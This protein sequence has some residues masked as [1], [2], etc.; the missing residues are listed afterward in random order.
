[1]SRRNR[2]DPGPTVRGREL[3]RWLRWA[4]QDAKLNG[5]ELADA[6]GV[7]ETT[8]SRMTTGRFVATP[9]EA[10]ALLAVCRVTGER[11]DRI[12]ELAGESQDA[13]V[14]RLPTMELWSAYLWHAGEAA[15]VIEYYPTMIPWLAQT[16]EYATAQ[17]TSRGIDDSE[18][19]NE[20]LVQRR[21][22]SGLLSGRRVVLFVHEWALCQVV[23]DRQ[24]MSAQLHHLLRLM[25]RPRVTV[26]VVP[27]NAWGSVSFGS[28][29]LLEFDDL[30][31]IVHREEPV[32]GLLLG[33]ED[34]VA[35]HR[36]IVDHLKVIAYN[37]TRS[38]EIIADLAVRLDELPEA[39][40]SVAN[41]SEL[42]SAP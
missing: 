21:A 32:A 42:V 4:Q 35:A 10:A 34:D 3:G 12:V 14:L 31:A 38:R 24:L 8:L 9:V 41:W 17:L 39:G 26:R 33:S 6:L 36:S 16:D 1:M 5:R 20:H 7:S 25:V 27:F 29:G 13:D 28:F 19:L 22:S 40:D 23:G 2:R 30:P 11:R 37:S 18:A 15:R